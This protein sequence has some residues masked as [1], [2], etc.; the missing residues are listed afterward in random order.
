[1]IFLVFAGPLAALFTSDPA[2]QSVTRECLRFIALG[3]VC[4]AWGW[5]LMQ[6][7]N[8]A[9]DTKTPLEAELPLLLVLPDSA[10]LHARVSAPP[11]LSRSVYC[12][13]RRGN[14]I[15]HLLAHAVPPRGLEAQTDLAIPH[16][17]A[18]RVAV[19]SEA[20]TEPRA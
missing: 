9:G 15:H 5:V 1:V 13:T 18:L 14:A 12:N 3:N 6:A 11:G 2:V 19:D 8:G 4:Y 17:H 7:F 10:G 20:I 16:G